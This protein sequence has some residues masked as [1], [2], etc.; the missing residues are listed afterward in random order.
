MRVHTPHMETTGGVLTRRRSVG[1]WINNQMY[2]HLSSLFSGYC[3]IFGIFSKIKKYTHIPSQS[4][5]YSITFGIFWNMYHSLSRGL[6]Q[7]IQNIQRYLN[8]HTV[9]CIQFF[10]NIC[11]HSLHPYPSGMLE[12]F[13]CPAHIC[14]Y[15]YM[16]LLS[17]SPLLPARTANNSIEGR[18]HLT[19]IP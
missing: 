15:I 16:Y 11:T 19:Y 6:Q 12:I 8:M 18:P 2:V 10:L 13:L 14:I 5:C 7:N 3:R 1:N 17:T 9:L 4:S